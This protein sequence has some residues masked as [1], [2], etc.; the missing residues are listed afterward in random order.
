MAKMKQVAK[1]G[2]MEEPEMDMRKI[3]KEIEFLGN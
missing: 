1:E 2:S 3:M